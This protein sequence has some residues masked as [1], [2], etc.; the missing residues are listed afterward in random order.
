[1]LPFVVLSKT[2][3]VTF[4]VT[5]RRIKRDI[6]CYH[7]HH[8]ERIT[9]VTFNV[10]TRTVTRESRVLLLMLPFVVLSESLSVTF[11]LPFTI[12]GDS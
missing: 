9:S 5:I 8:N 6:K 10:T 11:M 1:M 2:L 4:N 7:P 12:T 3:N